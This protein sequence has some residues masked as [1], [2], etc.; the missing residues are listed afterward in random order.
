MFDAVPAQPVVPLTQSPGYAAALRVLGVT[1]EEIAFCQQ[2][3]RA[4][5][6]LMQSRWLPV[7]GWVGLIS[8]GPLWTGVPDARLLAEELRRQ[9]HPVLVNADGMLP[10]DLRRAGMIPLLSEA[11]LAQLD[12]SGGATARRARMHQKWRNR[13]VRAEDSGLQVQRSVLPVD[14]GHWLL[15]AEEEQRK[16][17]KYRGL[18]AGVAAAY[19]RENPGHAQIFTAYYKGECVAAMLFLIH[20]PSATYFIGHTTETGRGLNAHALLLSRASDWLAR[21]AVDT[22]DLGTV[23]TVNAP[24]LARFKLGSGAQLRKL[25]GTW[26]YSRA[27]APVVRAR[28]AGKAG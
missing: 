16:A 18:P 15:R 12:L 23:D 7:L 25:G 9:K 22:L 1:V 21:E 26:L 11:S 13:L 14:P 4:G 24:G 3:Y 28:R 27:L 5:H 19:S 8:R 10:H 20:G 2:G 6:A 17:K